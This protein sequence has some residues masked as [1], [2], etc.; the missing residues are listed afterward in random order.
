MSIIS[1]E[2]LDKCRVLEQ[3]EEESNYIMS[4]S[5]MRNDVDMEYNYVLTTLIVHR[6]GDYSNLVNLETNYI[7]NQSNQMTLIKEKLEE[8]I[9]KF[10]VKTIVIDPT[11]TGSML[12]H[13][14]SDKY[15]EKIF[16]IKAIDVMRHDFILKM[17]NDFQNNMIRLPK[18]FVN[19]EFDM[20]AQD[21]E[22]T[23]LEVNAN[24]LRIK[25]GTERLFVLLAYFNY[26][27]QNK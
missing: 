15:K 11:G 17:I 9:N 5:L 1:E 21:L 4:V 16:E 19:A 26:L 13:I 2:Y 12:V 8:K 10:N 14:L 3:I 7:P 18:R 23:V 20:L 22:H 6:N 27:M 25:N 24:K